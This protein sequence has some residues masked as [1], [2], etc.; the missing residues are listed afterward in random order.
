MKKALL[1]DTFREIKNTKKRFI[2]ILL[3]AFLGV[4]F[5]AGIKAT[6]P[7]M[8]KT[9]D[10][11]YDENN[12]YDIEI[13]STLGLTDEDI[14]SLEK[15]DEVEKAYGIYS[16][17]V[18]VEVNGKETISKVY[19][20]DENINKITLTS[21]TMPANYDECL[22]EES[23]LKS[24]N[25]QIGDYIELDTK[26]DD[27][28]F[29]EN[30]VKIVGTVSSP[31]YISRSRGSTKLGSG[32]INYYMYVLQENINS[33]IYTGIYVTVKD[34]NKLNTC[35]DEYKDYIEEVKDKIE[36][37]KQ[38]REQARYNILISEAQ[39]KIDEA[40]EE[41][42]TQKQDA[43]KQINDAEIELQNAKN[44]INA[45]KNNLSVQKSTTNKQIEENRAQLEAQK[46]RLEQAKQEYQVKE[47]EAMNQI[48]NL[49][50]QIEAL[51]IDEEANA[52][53]IEQLEAL[54]LQI[55]TEVENG[56]TMLEQ[57]EVQITN[58][59]N[60]LETA[61]Q[62]ANKEFANAQTKIN[63]AEADYN[64]G[65]ATLEGKKQE[66]N[67]KIADAERK[68]ADAEEDI[69]SIETAKWY[70]LDRYSNSGFNSFV[71]DTQSIANLGKVFPIVFFVIAILISLTSMTRMV[72]EQ[73]GEVGTLK[74]LGYTGLQIANKYIIYAL[75]ACVIGG[76]IG[77]TVG[78]ILIPKV[79]W[80]MYCLMYQVPNFVVEFNVYYGSIG[81]FVIIVCV[82]GA[83]IF[84]IKKEIKQ[85]PAV[86]MR[87]KAPTIGKRVLLERVKFIWNRLSFIQKITV[88]NMFRYK[89]RFLLTIIGILGCTSLILAGFGIRD[90]ITSL[91][92]EQYGNIFKYDMMITTK[93]D[94]S[95]EEIQDF[96]ANLENRD[97]VEKV[98]ET[99]TASLEVYKEDSYE[100][101][102]L[103]V[104]NNTEDF[105]DVIEL[106]DKKTK[107]R[108][109]LNNNE[110]IITD[111]LSELIDVEIGDTVTL[112]N[113]DNEEVSATIGAIAKNNINH[114][115]YMTKD[116]YNN[117]Y[118]DYESNVLYVNNIELTEE[119]EDVFSKEIIDTGYV[120]GVSTTSDAK[121]MVDDMVSS[122]NY[123][124][125]V[126]IVS[127][128]LLAFVVL[129]NLANVNISERIRELAT[130]KVLGFYDK[131]VYDYLNRE[132]I[133]LTI[134][135]IIL[136]LVGGYFLSSFIMG[137]CE[138]KM[139]RF[140]KVINIQSYI[141][142][143]LITVIFTLI[144]NV[145]T[146]CTLK[147]IKMIESLKSV[148]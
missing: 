91:L 119:Q 53:Q 57:W 64:E 40:K 116:L 6:S 95:A 136:G 84:S 122:L 138:V 13:I 97:E 48:N 69:K 19:S 99:Y 106:K 141:Y 14:E 56:K 47:I 27:E 129:Y 77:M 36:E 103:V 126:L 24:N 147:K 21:G 98:V 58:G 52:A 80:I 142:A 17:D 139:L 49:T 20:I 81:L 118:G 68:I 71:Q 72:E 127:S 23:F 34:A 102:N 54:I 96:K 128:G 94:L 55:Q 132:T 86:L 110:I 18:A 108:L 87:P 111:K 148:E 11:Y 109:Q 28:V 143:I 12:L 45:A 125:V 25:L 29:N 79:I 75:L 10:N 22:V 42:N 107:E 134:V 89:K 37:I 35:L 66:L 63:S 137:T 61:V 5:F 74:T 39:S 124:V 15:I 133:I 101:A 73:R 33:E 117:L 100:S 38:E 112:R 60:E 2:S 130:I 41:V 90:S 120:A 135:G 51:K 121:S 67:E 3:M 50:A 82:L 114:Y 104:A 113:S 1:K 4:G 59:E 123:V 140:D 8:Q 146:Y 131:E 30:K 9:I 92:P 78:F 44:E 26:T 115:I 76:T 31:L 32:T 46:Q 65:V 85:M 43:E 83:T 145:F 93:T 144:V 70:V 105:Y 7:D 16:I 62:T 88:R